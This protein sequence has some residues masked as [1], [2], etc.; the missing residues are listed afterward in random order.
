MSGVINNPIEEL[1]NEV[2][3]LRET[4]FFWRLIS[5]ASVAL[6]FVALLIGSVMFGPP[7]SVKFR[8]DINNTPIQMEICKHDTAEH[9]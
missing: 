8:S 2:E 5:I 6:S 1:E 3:A 7:P 9:D 4:V